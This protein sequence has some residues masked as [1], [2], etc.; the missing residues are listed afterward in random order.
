MEEDLLE[1][2]LRQGQRTDVRTI[3]QV[4]RELAMILREEK[5]EEAMVLLRE[6]YMMAKRLVARLVELKGPEAGKKFFEEYPNYWK[7][8]L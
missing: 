5:M 1:K 3:C 7:E 6:S 8:K 2:H 4:H